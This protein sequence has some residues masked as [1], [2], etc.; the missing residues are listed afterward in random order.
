MFLFDDRIMRNLFIR[1]SLLFLR[2]RWIR[3]HRILTILTPPA[4]AIG[5][6]LRV[7]E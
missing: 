4:L 1:N 5:K 3:L 6:S 7:E 2:T